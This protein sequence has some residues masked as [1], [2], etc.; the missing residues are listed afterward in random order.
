M[1]NHNTR[2]LSTAEIPL[3]ETESGVLQDVEQVTE[4]KAQVWMDLSQPPL[5]PTSTS[6]SQHKKLP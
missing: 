1:S 6:Q 3:P 5:V 2:S 4:T